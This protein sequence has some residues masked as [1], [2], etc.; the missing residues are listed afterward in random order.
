MQIRR[1]T[2]L[3]FELRDDSV[4]DLARLLA[5]GDGL[6]RRTRW[7]ALAP[8][9]EA[10]VEVS[11][12]EREW[13]GELSS[14]RWQSID[15]VHRLPIWAERLIEQGLVISDQPQLVQHRRNDECVQQQRWWPL[16][17]LWHRSAR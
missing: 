3:F 10:E 2:T 15:Q 8:H 6:R 5:G 7:L 12:E 1:C 13:L 4:F 14:S 17:A 16:A 11:E 9:L